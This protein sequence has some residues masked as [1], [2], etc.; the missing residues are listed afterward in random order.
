MARYFRLL[1]IFLFAACASAQ[2]ISISNMTG[3]GTFTD[4]DYSTVIAA[5]ATATLS[6]GGNASVTIKG[7]STRDRGLNCTAAL[8]TQ[9]TV[10]FQFNS[11]DSLTVLLSG[12]GGNSSGNTLQL[13]G[14]FAVTS[15]TGAYAGKGGSGSMTINVTITSGG[16]GGPSNGNIGI[17]T[18]AGSGSGTLTGQVTALPS[19][20]PSGI[21]PIFS[22]VPIIQPGEWISIYGNNLATSST[23]WNNNFPQSLAGVSVTINGKLGFLYYVSP[24][25]ID[26]QAPDD[27]TQGCVN[28]TVSTPV[29]STTYAVV[30]AQQAPSLNLWPDNKHAAAIIYTSAG[31][32]LLAPTGSIPGL[33]TRPVQVGE[34]ISLFGVGFGPLQFAAPAGQVYN[35]PTGKTNYITEGISVTVGGVQAKV[36][37]AALSEEGQYLITI[38][39]PQVATGDQLIQATLFFPNPI[40]GDNTITQNNV[41]IAVQ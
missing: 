28:V 39:V 30:L 13:A 32:D 41:Y 6:P 15:G 2:T 21:I 19:I 29:G 12:P 31:Y 40:L 22:E 4:Q 11:T 27:T 8:V 33:A 23:S 7:T 36:Y 16:P 5:T 10:V 25:L 34:T 38:T 24:T 35:N 1:P 3:T 14:T 18:L 26:L 9:L 37:G 20:Y 17:F